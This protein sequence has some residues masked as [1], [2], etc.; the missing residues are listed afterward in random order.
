MI[1]LIAG[2]ANT[3]IAASVMGLELFGPHFGPYGATVAVVAFLMTGYRT[4]Y[5]SQILAR[6]KVEILTA[7]LNQPVS[8]DAK[9][10]FEFST[11]KRFV[12]LQQIVLDVWQWIRG[13]KFWR[14]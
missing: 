4:V 2:C 14:H 9:L 5:S 12:R 7:P 1:A 10:T 11:R 13:V 3:P 8:E 6:Q